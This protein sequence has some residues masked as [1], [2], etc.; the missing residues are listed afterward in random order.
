MDFVSMK[1]TERRGP[2]SR[3]QLD[4]MRRAGQ[5]PG[6]MAGSRFLVNYT[7]LLQMLEATMKGAQS[8]DK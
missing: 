8:G 7:A 4:S 1:E 2:L 5:L 6:I 3:R